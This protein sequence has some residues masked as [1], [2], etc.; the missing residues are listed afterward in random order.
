VRR[1]GPRTRALEA[2]FWAD[3]PAEG[4]DGQTLAR[5]ADRS[6]PLPPLRPPASGRLDD[7]GDSLMIP[8]VPVEPDHITADGLAKHN[9]R[10]GRILA[11]NLDD[12]VAAGA[13]G[14]RIGDL[15][16]AMVARAAVAYLLREIHPIAEADD[17]ARR[18]WRMLGDGSEVK[19]F[20][21]IC[22]HEYGLDDDA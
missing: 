8:M 6:E 11:R 5:T 3:D 13:D 2:L 4:L 16:S 20:L 12:A 7:E 21:A 10:I 18:L 22:A 9:A 19:E 14:R 17:L 15:T 1:H